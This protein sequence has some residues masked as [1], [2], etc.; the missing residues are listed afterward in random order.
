MRLILGLGLSEA[1][2]AGVVSVV[3]VDGRA[4][5]LEVEVDGAHLRLDVDIGGL[6]VAAGGRVNVGHSLVGDHGQVA[7]GTAVTAS[8]SATAS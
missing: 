1:A 8:S 7:A 2:L 5:G 6:S 4:G 3:D